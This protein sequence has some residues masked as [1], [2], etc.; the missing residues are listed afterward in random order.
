MY[1]ENYSVYGIR[2]VW[3]QLQREGSSVARCTIAQLMKSMGLVGVLRGKSENDS[4][5]ER[6]CGR[7]QGKPS[8]RG[9][10]PQPALG[11]RFYVR[12]YMAGVRL[13]GVH[14]RRV[15]RRYRGLAGVI[16]DGNHVRTG[17]AGAGSLGPAAIRHYP[18]LG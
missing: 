6:S 9:S 8:V 16:V 14:H 17:C 1:D 12:E 4:K 10:T 7:R 13:G 2:K 15:L 18:S 3:R 5:P 11:G